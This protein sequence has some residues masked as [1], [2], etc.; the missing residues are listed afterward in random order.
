MT[1]L[2]RKLANDSAV[3]MAGPLVVAALFVSVLARPTIALAGPPIIVGDG[4]AASC[5][6][7]TLWNALHSADLQGGGTILF[8]CGQAPV[9][10]VL[11]ATEQ[12]P[13]IGLLALRLPD[14]TRI[15]GGG[16]VTLQGAYPMGVSL[17]VNPDSSVVLRNL[18]ITLG[19]R[20]DPT[21][22]NSG[23]LTI[24]NTT[25]SDN[26]SHA[27]KNDGILIVRNSVFSHNGHF[28]S[29]TIVNNGRGTIVNSTFVSNLGGE[30]GAIYNLGT[31]DVKN[32]TFSGNTADGDGGAI[33]SWGA[34]TVS[35]CV[36]S[37]NYASVG[38]GGAIF[39]GGDSFTVRHSTF[40]GNVV[41]G[42]GGGALFNYVGSSATVASSSFL[43]NK[44][45]FGGGI[46]TYGPL[47]I[48]G[49][50]FSGNHAHRGGAIETSTD[51]DVA[52]IVKNTT[53]TANSADQD[54]GGISIK[55]G[56]S[57]ILI[58]SSVTG[59]TPNDI[60]PEL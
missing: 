54:G 56:P 2:T 59:N 36:F 15:D 19:S 13:T 16:R 43:K 14:N 4:T 20:E 31:L 24:E 45:A 9:T 47:T 42:A 6:Q 50:L 12:D 49:S 58:R 30:G 37:Y 34:L 35:N 33:S 21:V 23:T 39:N 25:F 38:V 11:T 41:N 52:M 22:L 5:V 55:N 48:T 26:V 28:P 29:A 53:I 8:R 10:I 40:V 27:I 1:K 3:P 51:D 7:L 44:G 57:P 17:V 32:S 18:T 60:G 46:L